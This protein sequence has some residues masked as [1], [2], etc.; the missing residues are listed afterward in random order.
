MDG[1]F[2]A[3][4]PAVEQTASRLGDQRPKLR[5]QVVDLVGELPVPAGQAA[6][7]VFGGGGGVNGAIAGAELEAGFPKRSRGSAAQLLAQIG[8][9]GHQERL[10]LVDRRCTG[11]N[12]A[13]TGD[14]QHTDDFDQAITGLGHGAGAAGQGGLG[15]GIG[16]DGIGLALVS[17]CLAVGPVHVDNL[18]LGLMEVTGQSGAVSAGALDSH[19]ARRPKLRIH[20]SR[21]A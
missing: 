5:I 19:M 1:C 11:L 16:V 3:D 4:P 17:A 18:H 12:R 13:G 8:L 14:V 20:C 10:E 9:R 7:G 15:S 2:E 21:A 6:Q